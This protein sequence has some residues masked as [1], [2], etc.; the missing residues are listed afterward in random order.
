[1]TITNLLSS[2]LLSIGLFFIGVAMSILWQQ[3][4]SKADRESAWGC[5]LIGIPPTVLGG[6]LSGRWGWLLAGIPL[7]VVVGWLIWDLPRQPTLS[8]QDRSLELEAI[9]L[10]QIQENNGNITAISLALAAKLPLDDAKQ[11]LEQKSIELH[12]TRHV[13]ETGGIYYHFNI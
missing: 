7:S 1:M 3:H 11:Y 12:S 5:L 10:Q 8:R 9:F 4:P 13:N 2:I 6:W